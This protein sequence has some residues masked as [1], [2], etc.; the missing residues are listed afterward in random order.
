MKLYVVLEK[1]AEGGYTAYI[2]A[3]PGCVSQGESKEE[4]LKNIREAK[5]LYLE[6]LTSQELKRLLSKVQVIPEAV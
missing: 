1:Q 3:L 6:D 4:T 2:P 5:E